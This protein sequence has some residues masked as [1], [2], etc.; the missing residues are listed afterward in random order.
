M[1]KEANNITTQ[2]ANTTT[3]VQ[4]VSNDWKA[5]L[6]K[7]S[8]TAIVSNVPFLSFVAVLCVLYISS[9]KR[10][11]DIQRELNSQN[12][13]LKELRWEYMD[14]KS[15]MMHAQMEI[16]VIKNADKIGLQPM[17]TPAFTIKKDTITQ[18]QNL[19]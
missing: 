4:R 7:L 3:P 18:N 14:T 1:S 17:L 6:E 11:V 5:L 13:I 10:A 8:Y 2:E 9:N 19:N 15:Q 16:E 12:E